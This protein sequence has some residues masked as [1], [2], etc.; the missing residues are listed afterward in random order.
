M[1]P[2][3]KQVTF[4]AFGCWNQMEQVLGACCRFLM[5]VLWKHTEFNCFVLIDP[6]YCGN[7]LFILYVDAIVTE[8]LSLHLPIM[9]V[10]GLW[11]HLM[12]PIHSQPT[13]S[14]LCSLHILKLLLP[15]DSLHSVQQ[16]HSTS[17]ASGFQNR[18]VHL[19]YDFLWACFLFSIVFVI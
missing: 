14:L 9:R 12:R 17:Q 18:L 19:Q 15:M 2:S 8:G 10:P 1:L 13:C 7:W 4:S 5:D 16:K 11:L 6:F 3:W